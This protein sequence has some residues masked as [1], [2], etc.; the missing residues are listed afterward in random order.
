LLFL[1]VLIIPSYAQDTTREEALAAIQ[2]AELDMQEMVENGF[3]VGNVND[4]LSLARQ[5]L[6]RADF[7]ELIRTGTQVYL[8][9]QAKK[10]L[11]GLDYEGFTYDEIL[12]HTQEISARK[13]EA[14]RLSDSIRAT[15]LKIG[16]YKAQ[17]I[18]TFE[19]EA[20][21]QEAKTAFEKERYDEVDSLLFNAN[22]NL[23]EKK[24]EVTTINVLV[25]S[26]KS[27]IE[28]KWREITIAAL[29]MIV[30][31]FVTWKQIRLKRIRK[32]L[33]K[34]KAEKQ[35]LLNLMKKVQTERFKEGKISEFIYKI[36]METYN[37]RLN[38]VKEEIPVLEAMLK[39]EKV[40]AAKQK[41]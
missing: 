13:E 24:A 40:R 15:E 8:A 10:A 23:E 35:A 19:A 37:K 5:A 20:I 21:L 9:E 28:K 18:D 27:Y 34:L 2:Q 25:R 1:S 22:A 16:D 41:K 33:G 31:A 17:G 30:L 29:I 36:R 11:E 7:A 4:T 38:E 12:K 39:R 6:E 14:Y 3:S 32:K 26:G